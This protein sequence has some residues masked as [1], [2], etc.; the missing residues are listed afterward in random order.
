MEVTNVKTGKAF[1]IKRG[2][3][4]KC[5]YV[6]FKDKQITVGGGV[7]EIT[8]ST[9]VYQRNYFGPREAIPISKIQ[10]IDRLSVKR[11][12]LPSLASGLISGGVIVLLGQKITPTYSGIFLPISL[13]STLTYVVQ[14]NNRKLNKNKVGQ[15]VRLQV[16]HKDSTGKT[17]TDKSTT[18]IATSDTLN[19]YY[20]KK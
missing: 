15:T 4:I 20:Q 2:D 16:F 12:I 6:L 17:I 3:S 18:K 14:L 1:V 10:N 5:R 19:I 7:K 8:D 13:I 9:L 11:Y